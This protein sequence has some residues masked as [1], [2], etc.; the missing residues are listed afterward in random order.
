[1]SPF[2]FTREGRQTLVYLVMAGCGPAL[3]AVVIWA[4]YVIRWWPD[5]TADARLDKFAQL[6]L[7]VAAA[8]III[9]IALSCFVSIRAIKGGVGK[10][11]INFDVNGGGGDDA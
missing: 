9:V 4:M 6:A 3:T 10:D 7:C 5:A 1:M 2:P 11:G 8:L